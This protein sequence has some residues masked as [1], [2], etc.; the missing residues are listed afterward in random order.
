MTKYWL[1]VRPSV[2][3]RAVVCC[4]SAYQYC[5]LLDVEVRTV[6]IIV[7]AILESYLHSKLENCQASVESTS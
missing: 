5:S 6:N 3:L 4:L 1:L 7:S 2:F